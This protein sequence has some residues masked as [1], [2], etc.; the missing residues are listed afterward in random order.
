MIFNHFFYSFQLFNCISWN[1]KISYYKRKNKYFRDNKRNDT[2]NYLAHWID[3]NT[4]ILRNHWIQ[5]VLKIIAGNL[6]DQEGTTKMFDRWII[7]YKN[8]GTFSLQL[9]LY[10]FLIQTYSQNATVQKKA[11]LSNKMKYLFTSASHVFLHPLIAIFDNKRIVRHTNRP[12]HSFL[13]NASSL[14]YP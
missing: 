1:F 2:I 14:V 6:S 10:L 9:W 7:I 11:T 12:R 3:A 13:P 4:A 5:Y 8:T